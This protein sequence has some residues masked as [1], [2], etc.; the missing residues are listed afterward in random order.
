MSLD[1]KLKKQSVVKYHDLSNAGYIIT[2]SNPT[3]TKA[4]SVTAQV[5]TTKGKTYSDV[6]YYIL[7]TAVNTTTNR[8]ST[9]VIGK[10][11][12]RLNNKNGDWVP[13]AQGDRSDIFVGEPLSERDEA[14]FTLVAGITRE[15]LVSGAEDAEIHESQGKSY[16]TEENLKEI[17]VVSVP[18]KTYIA[19]SIMGKP[20]V[21][22][23][24]AA[25]NLLKCAGYSFYNFVG[26]YNL[27]LGKDK[28]DMPLWLMPSM[29]TAKDKFA[30]AK[31]AN[32]IVYYPEYHLPF[33]D[34][35]ITVVSTEQESAARYI[36][37]DNVEI[38]RQTVDHLTNTMSVNKSVEADAAYTAGV[39]GLIGTGVTIPVAAASWVVGFGSGIAAKVAEAQAGR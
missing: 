31:A 9:T 2:D 19:Y 20:F 10:K 4:H 33:T 13:I 18:N 22:A 8:F 16:R 12:A 38:K 28:A 27:T 23:G 32:E 35:T 39:A 11:I 26:G 37:K 14:F 3:N 5:T 6:E 30:V 24:V 15:T 34:N 25:W 29:K 7:E 1:G 17:T 36:T 21:I